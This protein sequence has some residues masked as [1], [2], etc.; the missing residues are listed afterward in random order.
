MVNSPP[1]NPGASDWLQTLV[2]SPNE[3]PVASTGSPGGS[4]G[5]GRVRAARALLSTRLADLGLLYGTP[6]LGAAW[7][8]D[9]APPER[10]FLAVHLGLVALGHALAD[11]MGRPRARRE[12]DLAIAF[13]AFSGE[14]RAA[15]ALARQPAPEASSIDRAL[16]KA[17]RVLA[18]RKEPLVADPV[19]GVPLHN[20]LNYI[21]ARAFGRIALAYFAEDRLDAN[22]AARRLAHAR[23]NK[24][25]LLDALVQLA[26][27]NGPPSPTARRAVLR[28]I[29][30]LG[31]DR[32][33]ARALREILERPPGPQD[34][35][36]R[37]HGRELRQ[38][39]LAQAILASLVDGAH[40]SSERRFLAELAGAFSVSPLEVRQ[41]EL[42]LA[43]FYA[44]HR[45]MVDTFTASE[46][47]RELADEL[48]DDLSHTL[49]KNLT[50]VAQELRQTGELAEL[51]TKSARGA[52]LS[53]DERA[54]LKQN[55]VDVAKAVPSLA[56]L[57][58]P[59]GLLLLGALTRV[60]PFNILPSAWEKPRKREP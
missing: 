59:G 19:Y 52:P 55:L 49:E 3:A 30:G 56:L 10:L 21:D 20:G 31:L 27:A 5:L 16:A 45:D 41:L 6:L 14:H 26:W 51:L 47:G 35:A 8:P 44:E 39:V 1:L 42:A 37:V 33:T 9:L 22:T 15:A 46:A 13:L 25:V 57:A 12:L 48:I 58:A 32:A 38:F 50:A 36:Q 29:S 24:A 2:R 17:A 43:A 40:S 11:A 54:R 34:L 23:R 53:A 28:Q 4:I 7:A 60:L 18:R